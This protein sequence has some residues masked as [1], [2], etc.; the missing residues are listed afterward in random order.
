[1]NAVGE[2][3]MAGGSAKQK[4]LEAVKKLPA[5]MMATALSWTRLAPVTRGSQM[6]ASVG[7][8]LGEGQVLARGSPRRSRE[9][10]PL[11][12]DRAAGRLATGYW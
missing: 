11:A 9:G 5:L 4:A 7:R 10:A 6:A 8:G 2:N 3:P 1:V 12:V